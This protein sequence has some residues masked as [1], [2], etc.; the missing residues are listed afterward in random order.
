MKMVINVEFEQAFDFG[1]I[2]TANRNFGQRYEVISTTQI[3]PY[4][5]KPIKFDSE[6][7]QEGKLFYKVGS[8]IGDILP[9]YTK[10]NKV[11]KSKIKLWNH[12][13]Q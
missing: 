3:R 8:V 10:F 13:T 6:D 9:G 11:I 7:F 12:K 1:S 4:P 5:N 2:I